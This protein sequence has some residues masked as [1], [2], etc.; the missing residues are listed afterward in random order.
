MLRK[1]STILVVLLVA[2]ARAND[3]PGTEFWDLQA[4]I[5][6]SFKKQ[7]YPAALEQLKK[8]DALVPNRPSSVL[9]MARAHA[10][11][12]ENDAA[13]T[14][15]NRLRDMQTY[16]DL[17]H[18]P[19]FVDLQKT[20]GFENLV[21]SMEKVSESRVTAATVAFKIPDTTFF[22]E[23]IAYDTHTG[24]VFVASMRK[25]KIVRITPTGTITDFITPHH[26]NIWGISGIGIDA[27][28]N[29]LWACSTAYEVSEEYS[30]T[31]RD[32]AAFAFD[33]ASGK[34][35]AHYPFHQQGEKHFCDGVV[36][37]SDGTVFVADSQGMALL[38]ISPGAKEL[39]TLLPESAGISPQ[40]MAVSAD[41]KTL[42]FSDYMS[43][44]YALNLKTKQVSR[45]ES[46]A[47]ASLAGIDGLIGYGNDL[48]AIQNGILPNRVVRLK[49]GPSQKEVLDVQV[50]EMNHP[51][52]GE[53][54]L[55]VIKGN[56]LLLV[57]N[58]PIS[59]FLDDHQLSD[60]PTPVILQRDL[61]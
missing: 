37:A 59:K 9:R 4:Q 25:R 56:M 21:S 32:A 43:G 52:F 55:G 18:D 30:P 15:L 5:A 46:K 33:L 58:N 47:K 17:A 22:P 8:S 34:L 23:G 14:L 35:K 20:P 26:D 19:A 13:M 54:T 51:L 53:P 31:D 2:T 29:T 38:K 11:L 42:F 28:H 36:I 7:D 40:G 61:R 60:L 50:L 16:F 41:G 12:H 49:M 27:A 39:E 57:A 1:G 44:L 10:R 6:E 24:D 48:I 3:L 45:L